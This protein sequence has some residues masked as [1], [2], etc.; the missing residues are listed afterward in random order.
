MTKA[1]NLIPKFLRNPEDIFSGVPFSGSNNW[2]A[3]QIRTPLTLERSK[4]FVNVKDDKTIA[5][6][7]SEYTNS[8]EIRALFKLVRYVIPIKGF[9]KG[10]FK[11]IFTDGFFAGDHPS[12]FAV[13]GSKY[14]TQGQLLDEIY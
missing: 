9:V 2:S 6:D 10:K 5:S 12:A 13:N 14:P 3:V 8:R 11:G 1:T 4:I 7:A